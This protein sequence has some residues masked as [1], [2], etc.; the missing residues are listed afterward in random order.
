ML[1]D[2]GKSIKSLHFG[3]LHTNYVYS[4]ARGIDV[5]VA[6]TLKG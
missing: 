1:E 3:V 6:K 2:E 5:K 4:L